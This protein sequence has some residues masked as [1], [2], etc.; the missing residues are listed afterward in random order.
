MDIEN[1]DISDQELIRAVRKRLL[2]DIENRKEAERI[3]NNIYGG[4]V[5]SGGVMDRLAHQPEMGGEGGGG[6]DFDYFVDIVRR[7]LPEL[8]PETGKP[9]GWEKKVH[10]FRNK[11][12]MMGEEE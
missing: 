4:P 7:D 12:K 10:R 3:V 5:G 9:I 1:E 6:D 11:K 8:H 2:A